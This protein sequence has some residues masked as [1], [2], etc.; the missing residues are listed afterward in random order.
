MS[1]SYIIIRYIIIMSYIII[2]PENY[3]RE[4]TEI[5]GTLHCHHKTRKISERS[6][7]LAEKSYI[8]SSFERLHET[9]S[10]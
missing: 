8:I 1:M 10:T 7:K 3:C 2:K 5:P 6:R 9:S 4:T